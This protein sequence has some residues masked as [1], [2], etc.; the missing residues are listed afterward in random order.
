MKHTASELRYTADLLQPDGNTVLVTGAGCGLEDLSGR[1]L[2]QQQLESS[3][4]THMVLLWYADG[5]SLPKQGYVRID[6]LDGTPPV[7]YVVDYT[8]DARKPRARVWLEVYCHVVRVN[9]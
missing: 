3:E 2:E 1:R 9:A 5:V 8:L 6:M 7:L 4:T